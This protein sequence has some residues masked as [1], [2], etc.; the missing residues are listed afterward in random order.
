MNT[1]FH[2][3]WTKETVQ[4]I[5]K[6]FKNSKYDYLCVGSRTFDE[7]FKLYGRE[8]TSI[9]RAWKPHKTEKYEPGDRSLFNLH[10]R[11]LRL[12]FLHHCLTLLK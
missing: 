11:Q 12:E 8:I 3:V 7:L 1:P 9:A 5:L 4:T 2:E 6:E 10:S